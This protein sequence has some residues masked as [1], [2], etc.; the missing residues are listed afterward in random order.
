MVLIGIGQGTYFNGLYQGVEWND[1]EMGLIKSLAFGLVIIWICA[2]KGYL[3]HRRRVG[4]FG[5]EGVSHVTTDAVVFSSV[6]ILFTDY[7]IGSIML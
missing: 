2:A 6:T 1:I 5:A 4:V 7:L 3:L